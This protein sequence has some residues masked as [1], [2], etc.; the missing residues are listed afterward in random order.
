MNIL[1]YKDKVQYVK[2]EVKSCLKYNELKHLD[3]YKDKAKDTI[4]DLRELRY[5]NPES[6]EEIDK[7]IKELEDTIK[8]IDIVLKAVGE[9]KD[10]DVTLKDILNLI[11]FGCRFVDNPKE[12]IKRL[13]S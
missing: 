1:N 4:S 9:T 8:D 6:R 5:N 13:L 12:A 7:S 10:D 3:K 2:D 11:D